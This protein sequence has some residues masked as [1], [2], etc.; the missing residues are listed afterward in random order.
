M[1]G[2]TDLARKAEILRSLHVPGDPLVLTACR[3]RSWSSD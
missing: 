3:P 1:S 2:P